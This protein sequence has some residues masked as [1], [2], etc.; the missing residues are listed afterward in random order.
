MAQVANKDSKEVKKAEEENESKA[1]AA[2]AE[3]PTEIHSV[4]DKT[5]TQDAKEVQA[6]EEKSSSESSPDSKY[7]NNVTFNF[8]L[9]KLVKFKWTRPH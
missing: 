4:K 9:A 2:A 5:D 8:L 7:N 6:S 3:R 1:P